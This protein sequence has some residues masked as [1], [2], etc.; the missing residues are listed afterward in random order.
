MTASQRWW[1]GLAP[2]AA[3]GILLA[4][5][6]RAGDDSA[7]GRLRKDVT[8]LASDE[9]EGRG[10][11]T[12]G[13]NLASGYI[14]DSFRRA[15]LSPAGPAGSYFQSFTIATGAARMDGPVAVRLRGPGDEAINLRLD[16][17]FRP[18]GIS[19]AGKVSGP[20]V[21]AGYGIS[22]PEAAYDDYQGLDV[23]GKVVLILRRDPNAHAPSPHAANGM[24]PHHA[25]LVT[26][27]VNADLHKAAAVLF[28]ND[29]SQAKEGD[30]L[31]EF[32]ATAQAA[33]PAAVP[34]VH[35]RRAMVDRLLRSAAGL[36]LTQAQERIDRDRKPCS[37][38][39]RGWFADLDVSVHRT[40]ATAKNIVGVC[41]GSG[42]LAGE[43]IVIGAHYDHL[44]YGGRGSLARDR[45]PAIHH[46][47]DDNASGTSVLLELARRFGQQ[48]D[49]QGRRLVFVAFSGEESGLLGSEYY[50][51]HPLFPLETTA[52]MVNMDMVGRLRPDRTSGKEKLVVYGTSTS[53][54]FG[55][56]VDSV[57]GRFGLQVQKVP[58]ATLA[59]ERSTSDH[60]SFYAKQVPVL[61]LFTGNHADYHRPSD[62]ADKI[63]VPGMHRVADFAQEIVGRLA[64]TPARPTYVKVSSASPGAVSYAG[65]RMP[66]LGIR[67]SYGDEG[68]GVL[69]D[70]VSDG[71]PAARA[72]LKEGDRIVEL[73]G[74]PV[75]GLDAY[76]VL[77]VRQKRGQ[78]LSVGIIRGG[79]RLT[80][81][82]TPE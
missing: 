47:A 41:N 20:I 26:K 13:I 10:I 30:P 76:M 17:E 75:K 64:A 37:M 42:P 54:S 43:S 4:A 19:G 68:E 80:V 8:F 50:C 77:M 48:R 31:L 45:S 58:G 7:D 62:T 69:L 1:R 53:P 15:G 40:T 28:V 71:G 3:V 61:F 32:A 70:G 51:K 60:A 63:N 72:G 46:G 79:K 9:C 14:A 73:G 52:A 33:A 29:A 21:F 55:Q 67:P 34:A 56:L 23:T 35:L 12:K 57:N 2:V 36:G 44:G 39:L 6:A 78:A 81:Q 22:A 18:L 65:G 66:R 27:L 59:S 25:A 5:Q 11:A 49:R 24:S 16:E 38:V 82:V 74:L